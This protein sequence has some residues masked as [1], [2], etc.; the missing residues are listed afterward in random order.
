MAGG[1]TKA[2]VAA[3]IANGI[4]AIAKFTAAAITGSSAM[5]SEG[6]HS[7]ADTGNQALLLLGNRRSHR[8]PDRQHPFGYGQEL[9]FWSLIVAMILFGLGGGF[10]IY[11]GIA[12]L[13]H[14]EVPGDPIWIYS[15]LGVAFVVEAIALKVAL[16]ELGGKGSG[17][18]LWARVRAC[19][20]PRV[21]VPVAEDFAALVG[22]VVA[23]LGVFLARAL[24]LPVLDGAASI[25]IGIILA[26]VAVFLG[27]ETRALLVGETISDALRRSI[28]EIVDE[29][30]SVSE[31]VRMAG[32][33]LGPEE[34]LLN[35]GVRFL[36]GNDAE[37]VARAVERIEKKIRV[38]DPRVT[39][40]FIEPET[41]A[42]RGGLQV[43]F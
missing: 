26:L 38:L 31:V 15:V 4:I 9:Y 42:D 37:S 8:P 39:R 28:R 1:G 11:E 10:S 6:I 29:D 7:V 13:S 36:P 27:Y 21:F 5:L 18:S 25:V 20:D 24:D 33:H 32:V 19:S 35:L 3:M 30:D 2:V 34:I 16:G 12:H 40:V 22:V 23:F 43:P 41:A 17:Q 14:P